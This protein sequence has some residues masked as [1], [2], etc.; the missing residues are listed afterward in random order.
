MSRY[1]YIIWDWNG[2]LLDDLD[3]CINVMNE[4]LNKRSLPLLDSD[5]YKEIIE[6]PIVNYYRKLGFDFSVESFEV[7]AIEYI[8]KY[9][10]DSLHAN[11]NK[12]AIEI[13]K[14]IQAGGIEQVILSA[15]QIDNLVEQVNH[16]KIDSYFKSLI[17]LENCHAVS[18]ISAGKSWL[19][20]MDVNNKEVLLIGDTS[21][22]FQTAKELGCDCLLIAIGHECKNKLIAHGVPVIDDL[23]TVKAYL[24]LEASNEKQ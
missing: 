8:S 20:K 15:S 10:K 9:Q 2:T 24:N 19:Q 18:K 1:K 7:L 4:M 3:I 22:D 21:H 23:Q 12:D 13:L 5:R 6:F 16:F 11:L 17:G 14:C